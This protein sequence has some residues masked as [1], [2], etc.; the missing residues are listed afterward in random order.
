[1][2]SALTLLST[3][4]LDKIVAMSLDLPIFIPYDNGH[5]LAGEKINPNIYPLVVVVPFILFE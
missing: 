5:V 3:S 2:M 4:V 1:M